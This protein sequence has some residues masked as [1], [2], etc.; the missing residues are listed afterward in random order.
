LYHFGINLFRLS[1]LGGA[2]QRRLS[3]I[4]Y[5]AVVSSFMSDF[6]VHE[7]EHGIDRVF[8]LRGPWSDKLVSE[9]ESRKT[10]TLRLSYSAGFRQSDFSFVSSLTFLRGLEIYS[11]EV[12]D[13]RPIES[14]HE[15]EVLGLQVKRSAAIDFSLL[16][17]LRVVKV[18]WHKSMAG[19]LSGKKIEHLNIKNFPFGDLTALSHLAELR[20][21]YLSSRKIKSLNGIER[22][23]ALELLDLYNCP[24]LESLNG[25]EQCDSLQ[26]IEIE[27]CRHISRPRLILNPGAV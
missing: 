15:L 3:P 24:Y 17:N 27:A 2:F 4:R 10:S 25:T 23:K 26:K 22:L 1:D 8:I 21:L 14:L 6:E 20:R 16:S 19:V 9:L 13:L 11:W 18:T 12:T 7:D 5:A